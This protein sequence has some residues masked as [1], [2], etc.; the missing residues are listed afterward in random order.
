MQKE[1]QEL[2]E[3][4]GEVDL[5]NN[6]RLVDPGAEAMVTNDEI[7]IDTTE[8]N[9]EGSPNEEEKKKTSMP[10][11][12]IKNLTKF[13]SQRKLRTFKAKQKAEK[14]RTKLGQKKKKTLKW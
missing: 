2:M 14:K 13:M 5:E 10:K 8:G 4:A 12:D 6:V 11:V 3:A 7:S 1:T 9:V